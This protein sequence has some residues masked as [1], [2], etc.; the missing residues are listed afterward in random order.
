MSQPAPGSAGPPLDPYSPLNRVGAGEIGAVEVDPAALARRVL[1]CT[2]VVAMHGGFSG[3]AAT[4]LPG[5][6]VVG[7]RILPDRVEV[8]VV[9]RWPIPAGEV[10]A[11]IWAATAQA[12]QGRPVDVVISDVLIPALLAGAGP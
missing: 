7:V 8:H 1:A 9:S 4:Y 12:V 5:R 10:A 6:R 2:G 11:Q 3:E